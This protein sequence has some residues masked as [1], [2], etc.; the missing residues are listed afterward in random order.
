MKH[1][2]KAHGKCEGTNFR[3]TYFLCYIF[4][5]LYSDYTFVDSFVCQFWKN[6]AKLAPTIIKF[7]VY[8]QIAALK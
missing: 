4:C 2:V 6:V 1:W 7:A 8:F 5:K 3:K